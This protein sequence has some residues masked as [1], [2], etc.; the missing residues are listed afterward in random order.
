MFS[1]SE[2]LVYVLTANGV[3]GIL[4]CFKDLLKTAGDGVLATT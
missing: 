4:G 3:N 1:A 2:Q